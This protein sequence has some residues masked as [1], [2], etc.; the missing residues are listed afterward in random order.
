MPTLKAPFPYFGGKRRV[1]EEVWARFGNVRSYVEPF[2]GSGAVLLARP[3]PFHGVETVN[4]KDGLLC[5]F[6]RALQA[7]PA[8]VA[9]HADWPV[10]ECDLHARHLWLVERREDITGR[11]MVDPEWFDS[12]AAGWWVWAWCNM[13]IKR[14]AFTEHASPECASGPRRSGVAA[15]RETG[16]VLSAL[17]KVASRLS[18]VVVRCGS[19]ERVLQ[20]PSM[21]GSDGARYE[22][23]FLDPPYA[24]GDSNYGT[25]TALAADVREWAKVAG[26]EPSMRVALCGYDE[27]DEL[28]RLGWT[29]HKWSTQ[30]GYG[31]KSDGDGRANSA[32]EVVWFSPHCL[33]GKQLALF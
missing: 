3:T 5:N 9:K 10:S 20:S 16:D 4:D 30:G 33:S 8:S 32:R 14:N 12:R 7:D 23:V 25:G 2:F 28:G 11:L 24:E 15:I 29:A 17:R 13:A 19:W 6:W 1:A 26:Q 18:G 22:G 31:N 27:H 21:R